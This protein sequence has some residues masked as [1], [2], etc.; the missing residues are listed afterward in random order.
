[1]EKSFWTGP[2]EDYKK[3]GHDGILTGLDLPASKRIPEF[4]PHAIS[5]FQEGKE[6]E[7]EVGL[8][9]RYDFTSAISG[10]LTVNPDF[11]TVE[12]DQEQINLTR[13]ELNLPEKRNFFLEGNAIYNQ[14]ISLF[15]SRRISDILGAAKIYG[16]HGPN[17]MAF[18]SAQTN[19]EEGMG[20]GNFSVLRWKR[21]ILS[22]SNVGVLFANR[23]VDGHSRGALGLDTQ[24]Y[25]NSTIKLTGQLALSYGD[26]APTDMAFFLRPSYDSSTF[27]A[28]LRYSHLGEYFGDNVNAVGFIRDDNRKELDSAINKTFWFKGRLLDRIA[29]RSNYNIYWGMDSTLRSWDVFQQLI[30]DL[31]NKLSLRFRHNRDYKLFEKDFYNVSTLLELGYNTRAWQSA[32]VN[33]KFGKN[34]DADFTLVG[35]MLK[36]KITQDLSL[37]YGLTRLTLNPDPG[38]EDTWIHMLRATQYFNKDLFLKLFFQTNS[39]ID[40][41]NIQVIFAYRFQPPFGLVQIAYQK[42]TARFGEK[43]SQG[44]TLFVKLAW[45]F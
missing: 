7:F 23:L 32:A 12:A 39:A 36:R 30:C 24:L 18:L 29:Y 5:R 43:G 13:F 21:D 28:H 8:D 15:Y 45:V 4:I 14:R 16:K 38:D 31:Q 27:H 34:F 17:E 6:T 10:H 42:G 44:N 11:A 41:R 33:V 40:K 35:G 2:L 19:K 37:E 25:L 3:L 20:S 9:A 26:A 22:S 1:L